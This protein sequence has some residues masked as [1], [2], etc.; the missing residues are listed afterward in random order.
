MRRNRSGIVS[1]SQQTTLYCDVY[2]CESTVTALADIPGTEAEARRL[3]WRCVP[4]G[5]FCPENHKREEA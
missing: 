5:D 3:G 4:A 2:G 1:A